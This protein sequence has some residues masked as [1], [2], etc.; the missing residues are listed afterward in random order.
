MSKRIVVSLGGNAL[1]GGES[2]FCDQLTKIESSVCEIVD[3]IEYGYEI[4]ITHGNGPQVGR[5][6]LENE[7]C[8]ETPLAPL[9]VCVGMSQGMIGY[10]IEQ[11]LRN[12]MYKRGIRRGVA[13]VLTQVLVDKEDECFRK[14]SKPIGPFYDK[15][16][17][18]ELENKGYTLREDSGRGYRRVVASPRPI[19]IIEIEE[20]SEL[21]NRGC[22]VIACG[23]GG[24]PVIRDEKGIIKG[25]SGVIDKDFASSRLGQDIGAD[26]LLI[27]TAVDRVAL[28]FGK[29]DEILLEKVSIVD[30]ARYIGEGHFAAGSMLPKIEA[31]IEFVKSR[32]GRGAI[33][34]SLGKVIKGINGMEGTMITG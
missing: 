9:D 18:E 8:Q 13:V 20:I 21:M 34:T 1:E 27:I 24:I 11:A 3:L 32:E 17:A 14:P 28:N 29:R 7:M 31:S 16:R 30:L 19:E 6:L 26:K 2:T 5:I 12:E 10:Y 22:I 4:I 33:I 25:V 15:V 23:G